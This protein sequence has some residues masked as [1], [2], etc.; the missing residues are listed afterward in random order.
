MWQGVKESNP[1][2]RF[3]RPLGRHGL[4]PTVLV[5]RILFRL[6]GYENEEAGKPF[7]SPGL[8]EFRSLWNLGSEMAGRIEVLDARLAF[9]WQIAGGAEVRLDSPRAIRLC[10]R[11]RRGQF[12][13]LCGGGGHGRR[14]SWV[15]CY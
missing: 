6:R 13:L 7:G 11:L 9:E 12:R 3:W 14:W 15:G 8:S 2:L 5:L 1:R 4:R 10:R